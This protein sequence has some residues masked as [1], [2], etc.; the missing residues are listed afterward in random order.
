MQFPKTMS[1]WIAAAVVCATAAIAAPAVAK[2]FKYAIGFPPGSY[3]V[4]M[5]EDYAKRVKK[6]T[7]GRHSVRVFPMTLLNMAETSAGLRD[8]IAD[9]GFLLTPY[10]PAEYPHSN[11]PNEASMMLRLLGNEVQ[12]KEALAFV[13]ALTEFTFFNC[14]ECHQEFARQNQVYTGH[15]GGSSYGLVCNKPVRSIEELKGKRLRAGAA[16]WSRWATAVG[17]SPITMSANE[18]REALSQGVVDCI[19]LSAPE[20]HNFGLMDTISDITMAVPG[21]VFSTAAFNMN[22]KVWRSLSVEDRRA[23]LRAAAEGGAY[24]PW[25]YQQKEQAIL[26]EAKKKGVRLHEADAALVKKTQEFIEQD[27]NTIAKYFAD[28]HSVK[29]GEEMIRTFRP[30]LEKWVKL[31]QNVK[32]QDD[33]GAL[34][35][36]EIYSKVDVTRHGM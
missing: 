2:Q 16:N 12:G 31:V 36:N 7:D 27:M 21:G 9:I 30:I 17:A 3:N 25:I 34:Y 15:I 4:E 23:F 28:K 18:M 35:W 33:L 32:T 11:L 19:I 8:G 24:T 6:Y 22:V 5:A 26:E 13:G 10:F 20:I 29:R 1:R 14:P